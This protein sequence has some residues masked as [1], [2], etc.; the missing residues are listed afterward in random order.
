MMNHCRSQWQAARSNA[1][2]G[3]ARSNTGVVG[4]NPTRGIDVGV[5]LFCVCAGLCV[6]SGLA[7]GW[8]PSKGSYLLSI[9]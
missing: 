1:W 3:F 6:G 4:S 8:S 9:D 7:T 2:T 5:R